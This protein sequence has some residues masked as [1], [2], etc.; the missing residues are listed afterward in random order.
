M[1]GKEWA[2]ASLEYLITYGWAIVMIFVIVSALIVIAGAGVNSNTCTNFWGLICKGVGVEGD[3]FVLILQNGTGQKI[4]IN[5]FLDILFDGA[6]GYAIIV[7]Q[8]VEYRFDEVEIAAGDEFILRARGILLSK[9][10]CL[11]YE[12]Q[13]GLTKM[14]CSALNLGEEGNAISACGYTVDRAGTFVLDTDISAASGDCITIGSD[15]VTVDCQNHTI[16]GALGSGSAIQFNAGLQNVTVVNCNITGNFDTGIQANSCQ[17]ALISNN[18]VNADNFGI[19]VNV[20]IGSLVANNQAGGNMFGIFVRI[21]SDTAIRD[22]DT[23]GNM[24][25]I[26]VGGFSSN[27]SV[28]GNDASGN[29]FS[30][31]D[32]EDSVVSLNDNIANGNNLGGIDVRGSSTAAL[33]NNTV[34][35]TSVPD[36]ISCEGLLT[37]TGSGN[38][39]DWVNACPNLNFS[40]CP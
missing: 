39:A 11:N 30:G 22:N 21:S 2:Q 17:N 5:P 31:I 13:S 37:A 35:Y 12:N 28:S 18:Y 15:N 8:G 38:I 20:D 9:E 16:D 3:E 14:V 6:Y 36:D 1:P 19:T 40:A 4:A 33:N 34:C 29:T 10:I 25:G 32:I 26:H 24:T 7:Y 23:G 27:I